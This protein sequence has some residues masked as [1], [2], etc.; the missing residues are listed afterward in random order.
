MT[1]VCRLTVLFLSLA[2]VSAYAVPRVTSVEPDA[3]APGGSAVAN[4]SDLDRAHVDDL[5]LTAGGSDIL[6]KVTEQTADSITFEVPNSTE[7][8]R[9]RLMLLTA[10][11]GAAYMEQPVALEIVDEATAKQRAEEGEVE[12]EIIDAEPAEPEN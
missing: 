5:Y 3:V 4:G 6:V 12:L 7:M 10:G 2:V 9:Y 11:P 8:K 1:R